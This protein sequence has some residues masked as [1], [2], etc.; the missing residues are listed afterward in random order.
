MAVLAAILIVSACGGSGGS[1]TTAEGGV[2]TT[3]VVGTT[4]APTTTEDEG[5]GSPVGLD[6]IP[7]ECIDAFV[8][9]LQDIEPYLEGVDWANATM[10]DLEEVGTAIEPI[11]DEYDQATQDSNCDDLEVDATDEE[12]FQYLID[13]AQDEAP[14]T[15]PYLEMIRDF[16]GEG[17][18]GTDASGDCET[19]IAAFQELVDRGGTMQDLTFAELSTVGNLVTSITSNCTVERANEFFTK[20]DVAAWMGG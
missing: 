12:T 16:A 15:V 18:G 13:L 14:G 19:D 10:A 7:Q 11:S 20:E 2:S 9:F 1:T 3:D 5:G 6:D 17:G 4:E 8:A